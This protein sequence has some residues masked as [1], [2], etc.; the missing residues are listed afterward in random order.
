MV[1]C[2]GALGVH[3]GRLTVLRHWFSVPSAVIN[4]FL[5]LAIGTFVGALP[6][7]IKE[8]SEQGFEWITALHLLG[9][10]VLFTGYFG[11]IPILIIGALYG[12]RLSFVVRRE[13]VLW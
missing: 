5:S 7:F 10:P 8:V 9:G 4:G 13:R 12:I 2:G 3:V 1:L 11:A 6:F